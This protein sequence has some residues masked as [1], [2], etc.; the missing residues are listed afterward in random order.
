MLN[1]F[2]AQTIHQ[3]KPFSN[4][5]SLRDINIQLPINLPQNDI[6]HR[7][8]NEYT[9]NRPHMIRQAKIRVQ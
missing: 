2:K 5:K 4:R 1:N 8:K 3:V 6:G 7:A 9:V